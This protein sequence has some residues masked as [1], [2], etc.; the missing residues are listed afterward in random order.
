MTGRLIVVQPFF[1]HDRG[2]CHHSRVVNAAQSAAN[3]TLGVDGD[4]TETALGDL[5]PKNAAGTGN[6]VYLPSAWVSSG[7]TGVSLAAN[8]RILLAPKGFL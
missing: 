3:F 5:L 2:D 7:F 1:G 4:Q 6:T 8:A